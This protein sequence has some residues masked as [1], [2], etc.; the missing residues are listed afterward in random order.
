MLRKNIILETCFN[1]FIRQISDVK[2]VNIQ[3]ARIK[4]IMYKKS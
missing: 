2:V 1:Q 4:L 3:Y